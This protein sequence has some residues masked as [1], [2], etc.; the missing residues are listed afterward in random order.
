MAK[1]R[2]GPEGSIEAY[3]LYRDI[4]RLIKYILKPVKLTARAFL[5]SFST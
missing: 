3:L 5:L 4:N 2:P 1:E